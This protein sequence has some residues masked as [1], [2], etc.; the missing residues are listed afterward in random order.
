MLEQV[1]FLIGIISIAAIAGMAIG[2]SL[3]YDKAAQFYE[4]TDTEVDVLCE[5]LDKEMRHEAAIYTEEDAKADVARA[6]ERKAHG[7]HP[8]INR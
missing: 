2:Y 3:G 8:L 6:L 1:M 4:L 7:T 5:L